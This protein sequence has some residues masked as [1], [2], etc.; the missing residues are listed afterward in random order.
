MWIK[1]KIFADS[2]SNKVIIMNGILRILVVLILGFGACKSDKNKTPPVLSE[3]T[4][5]EDNIDVRK[6]QE[7]KTPTQPFAKINAPF[8]DLS[9][10]QK[11]YLMLTD[12]IWH[13]YFAL[14]LKEQAPKKNI[15]EGEWIDFLENG[16]YKKGLYDQTTDS[17]LY[18]YNSNSKFVELRSEVVDS[19]SEWDVRVDPDALL[20]IGTAKYNNN[21]WQ[22]KLMRRTLFPV[23]K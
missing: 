12:S 1:N 6:L 9:T 21:P 19:S 16:T 17:G 18:Y 22:I 10:K 2:L 8:K 5:Q 20:L 13:F 11:P 15:Y 7:I 14:S 3:Q 4:S 23:R